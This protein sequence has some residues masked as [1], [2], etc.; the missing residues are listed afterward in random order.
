MSKWQ[1]VILLILAISVLF[2]TINV[3][4][5]QIAVERLEQRI[6]DL[7]EASRD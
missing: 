2:T 5:L 3:L 4:R 7:A 1:R 6:S